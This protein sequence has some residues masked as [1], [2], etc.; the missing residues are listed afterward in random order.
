MLVIFP[1]WADG[2]L[3]LNS[4]AIHVIST[5]RT[6]VISDFTV[7]NKGVRS[8]C[9]ATNVKDLTICDYT[10]HRNGTRDAYYSGHVA[11]NLQDCNRVVVL[12]HIHSFACRKVHRSLMEQ[13]AYAK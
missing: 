12:N 3:A 11:Q 10:K 8:H 4:F 7:L 13:T 5:E 1:L 2:C 9:N 6:V